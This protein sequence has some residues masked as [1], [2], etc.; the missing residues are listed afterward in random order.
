MP[1]GGKRMLSLELNEKR[2]EELR[3]ETLRLTRKRVDGIEE[4][5]PKMTAYEFMVRCNQ[6]NME[7][8]AVNYFGRKYTYKEFIHQIDEKAKAFSELGV[9]PKDNVAMAM[10]M[11]P[12]AIIS[13]YALNKI[14]ASIHMINA[15]HDKPSVRDELIESR[16]TFL[17][18]DDI[19]YD[20]DWSSFVEESSIKSVCLVSLLESFP[21][22]YKFDK[23]RLQIVEAL[24]KIKN[25]FNKDEKC[26]TWRQ[27]SD[28]GE[29][30][31]AVVNPYYEP[32]MDSIIAST[33]G[34]TGKPKKPVQTNESL[35]AMPIQIGMTCRDFSMGDRIFATL[36]TW[37]Y[38]SLF[39]SVQHALCLGLEVCMDPLLNA[40][41]IDRS[42]RIYEFNHWNTIP[43]YVEEFANNKRLGRVNLKNQKTL[44][45]GGD[46]RSP[47][48][49]KLAESRF[50]EQ[51]V[52]VEISQGYG[53][54]ETGG[55]FSYTYERGMPDTSVGKPL[56]GNAFKVVSLET[57]EI[58]PANETGE[59]YLYSPTI[60][61]EYLD[62]PEET[63]KSIVVDENGVRWYKTEDVAHFDEE[64]NLFIDGRLRRIEITKDSNGNFTKTF[65]DK[66]KQVVSLHPSIDSCEVIMVPDPKRATRP[67]AFIVMKEGETFDSVVQN[68]ISMICADKKVESYAVPTEYIEVDH[69]PRNSGEKVDIDKLKEIYESRKLEQESLFSKAKKL[70][71]KRSTTQR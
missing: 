68:E 43:S 32:N 29:K 49:K 16:A 40:K 62:N 46:T 35:N 41:K 26:I 3:E 66:T 4:L 18:A 39:N 50:R 12:E 48:L 8:Y 47:K 67:V 52:D 63:E 71:M 70:I 1:K 15:T 61:K 42:M 55:C 57:G 11:T 44:V 19:F 30:S 33:T 10:L 13:F 2:L 5:I 31:Q 7:S 22:A 45:T 14:G 28:I 6:N 58:L 56:I 34:S 54:S 38:Y 24:M 17:I 20:K 60:M 64:G 69:L 23:F 37:I 21:I 36:P 9:K 53:S 51:G 59:L 65:P 27:L 25:K